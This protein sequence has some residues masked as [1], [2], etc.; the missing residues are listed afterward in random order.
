MTAIVPAPFQTFFRLNDGQAL[1]NAL[2]FPNVSTEDSI[3][4]HAGGGQS[5]AYQLTAT[6]S[7][8]TVVVSANDSV[9]L[10]VAN[11]GL[12]VWVINADSTDA[13]KVYG[14]YTAADTIN[15]IATGTGISQ[16]AGSNYQYTCTTA[17]NWVQLGGAAGS[18]TG[19]FNGTVG[20]STP[21]TGVFTTLTTNAKMVYTG[22]RVGTFINNGATAVTTANTL[23]TAN[24]MI[25][26]SLNTVGGT[27]GAIPAVTA[28]T[29]ATS[30]VTKGT[31]SDTST[32]NYAIVELA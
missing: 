29:A 22:A 4:A 17:G 12:N 27:V 10:P 7:R 26:V 13:M 1:D 25:L 21:S 28:F 15:G 3:T 2:A 20:A 6:I 19:T 11:V 14:N 5:S 8:V 30:F 16:P 9:Q 24:S 31:A 23:V 32:Y 18:Y